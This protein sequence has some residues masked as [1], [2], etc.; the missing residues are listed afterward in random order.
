MDTSQ[1]PPAFA[2]NAKKT[3]LE[4]KLRKKSLNTNE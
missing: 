1:I 3:S 2:G 4:N